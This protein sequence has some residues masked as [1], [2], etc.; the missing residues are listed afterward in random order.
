MINTIR[1]RPEDVG[2]QL[3]ADAAARCL[4]ELLNFAPDDLFFLIDGSHLQH[5][6]G[7]DCRCWVRRRLDDAYIRIRE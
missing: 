2:L 7:A 4:F 3:E 5:S 1:E 6:H